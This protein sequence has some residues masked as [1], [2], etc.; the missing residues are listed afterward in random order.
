MLT[1]NSVWLNQRINQLHSQW[2]CKSERVRNY[3]YNFLFLFF[4]S[5]R[6][7]KNL[8]PA[9]CLCLLLQ[10]FFP[11]SSKRR[12]VGSQQV[13]NQITE[14]VESF[15]QRSFL[16][17]TP[18]QKTSHKPLSMNSDFWEIPRELL[19]RTKIFF[20]QIFKRNLLNR[21]CNSSCPG[22]RK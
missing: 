4:F 18:M 9:L 5:L 10:T 11:Q 14:T 19:K 3:F 7:Q 12:S 15:G 17:D 13:K 21:Q 6:K 1:Q 20:Q 22:W 8:I 2:D 16:S